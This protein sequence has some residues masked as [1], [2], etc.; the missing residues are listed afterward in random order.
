MLT[1]PLLLL[2]EEEELSWAFS[3]QIIRSFKICVFFIKFIALFTEPLNRWIFLPKL[4]IYW[5][6]LNIYAFFC[7]LSIQSPESN[8]QYYFAIIVNKVPIL[9]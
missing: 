3:T 6:L 8:P 5:I 4:S 7:E 9:G 2:C 1:H